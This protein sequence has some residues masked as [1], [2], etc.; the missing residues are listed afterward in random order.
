M[1][2]TKTVRSFWR[3]AGLAGRRGRRWPQLARGLHKEAVPVAL[4][5]PAL[6]DTETKNTYMKPSLKL[7]G[8]L[9]VAT[10]ATALADVKLNENFTTSGRASLTGS[11]LM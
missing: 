1:G 4:R 8:L 5:R 9:A 3:N 11:F 10:A 2:I 7:A 6:P